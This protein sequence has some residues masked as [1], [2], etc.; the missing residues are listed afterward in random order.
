MLFS[1][2]TN[3]IVMLLSA[4]LSAASLPPAASLVS[5][6]PAS[7]SRCV[8]S[9]PRLIHSRVLFTPHLI[10]LFATPLFPCGSFPASLCPRVSF[11][12]STFPRFPFLPFPRFPFLLYLPAFTTF[13]TDHIYI[14]PIYKIFVGYVESNL[15]TFKR[16]ILF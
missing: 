15:K 7:H 2:K 14:L 11:P 6:P 12:A 9:L 1:I 5:L 16:K 4:S 13:L 8:L 10:P 3:I